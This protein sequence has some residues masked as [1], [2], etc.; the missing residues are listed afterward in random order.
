MR[1]AMLMLLM[2]MWLQGSIYIVDQNDSQVTFKATKMFFVDVDG[3]FKEFEGSFAIDNGKLTHVSGTIVVESINTQNQR[4]DNHL[5][6][7]GFFNVQHFPLM[8]FRTT[9]VTQNNVYG[10]LSIRD[11]SHPIVLKIVSLQEEDGLAQIELQGSV[12]RTQWGID[13]SF[14]SSVIDD[15]VKINI[16]LYGKI[17]Q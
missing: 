5:K 2:A 6:G 9:Q 16:V 17:Y 8:H 10:E 11:E 14:M 3:E 13:S 12:D 15:D 1:V 7:D 4:R